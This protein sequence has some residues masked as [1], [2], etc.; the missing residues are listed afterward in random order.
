MSRAGSALAYIGAVVLVN[1]GF[2]NQPGLDWFWSLLVGGVF[3]LRDV[4]QRSWGH[5][6]LVLMVLGALISWW[7][8]APAVALASATAFLVSETIDWLVYSLSKRPFADRVLLST[9]I[10]APVDSLIFL[11]MAHIFSSML[12]GINVAA[13][14]TASLIIYLLLKGR[15]RAS[16]IAPPASPNAIH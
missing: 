2:S 8:G 5:S 15:R 4:A 9:A 14:L 1:I 11:N 10:S 16:A 6:T 13:K 12:F 7:L 3:V